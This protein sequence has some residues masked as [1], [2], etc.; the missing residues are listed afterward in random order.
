MTVPYIWAGCEISWGLFERK[1]WF[2]PQP[3]CSLLAMV[4]S[5]CGIRGSFEQPS[6]HPN[7]KRCWCRVP[8]LVSSTGRMLLACTSLRDAQ[9]S[10]AFHSRT[11]VLCEVLLGNRTEEAHMEVHKKKTAGLA[12]VL[13]N[14]KKK[15]NHFG[16]YIDPPCSP[17]LEFLAFSQGH[18][19]AFG[20][21]G[22]QARVCTQSEAVLAD[23]RPRYHN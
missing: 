1:G 4:R 8:S 5:T 17:A 15:K 3:S 10:Q 11:R 12:I 6:Y 9:Q 21:S 22:H 7:R 18:P 19:K 23:I 2:D 16:K 20:G 14:T 13:R